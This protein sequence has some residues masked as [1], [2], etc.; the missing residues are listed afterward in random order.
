LQKERAAGQP[1]PKIML[2]CTGGVRCEKVS[3]YLLAAG[4]SDVN[5]LEGGINAYV[6]YAIGRENTLPA[7][8][9]EDVNVALAPNV[10]SLLLLFSFFSLFFYWTNLPTL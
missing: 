6:N 9:H 8:A 7:N 2:Y 4:F 10:R 3:S 1:D 5:Q